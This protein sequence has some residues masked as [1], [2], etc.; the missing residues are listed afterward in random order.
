[1]KKIL[2][3]FDGSAYSEG[4]LNYAL[5]ISK[6][7]TLI[8]G[9]FIEDLSYIG[10]TSFFGEEF[11][12]F[13]Y[14]VNNKIKEETETKIKQN[15]QLFENKCKTANAKYKVHFDKGVPV[16]ELVIESRYADLIVIGYQTFFS[17]ISK[18]AGEDFLKDVLSEA[19][20]PVIVVPEKYESIE[21]IIFAYDGKSQS[22]YAIKQFTYLFSEFLKTKN[23]TLLSISETKEQTLENETLIKEY[24][25]AHYPKITFEQ[26]SGKADEA[27]INFAELTTNP[28]IVMGSFGR[29]VF[30]RFFNPSIANKIIR[31]KTVPIFV[32]HK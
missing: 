24:L 25:S 7:E 2:V 12:V 14:D 3:A 30:S 17:S 23:I 13:D 15:I 22:V 18:I 29:N 32:S 9:V 10:F 19:E 6:K 28:L 20:C 16:R 8:V 27:I 31:K 26:I 1:M 4:A 5:N 21:N 11:L